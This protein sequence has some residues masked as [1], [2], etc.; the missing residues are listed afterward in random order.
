MVNT[1]EPPSLVFDTLD[2][3]GTSEERGGEGST[4]LKPKLE[5]RGVKEVDS[6][7]TFLSVLQSYFIQFNLLHRA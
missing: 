2:V 6:F 1:S 3:A 5:G 4:R 7:G